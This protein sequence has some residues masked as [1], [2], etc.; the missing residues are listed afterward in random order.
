LRLAGTYH[1]IAYLIERLDQFIPGI[2]TVHAVWK[3]RNGELQTENGKIAQSDT[4]GK[5]NAQKWRSKNLKLEW[6]KSFNPLNT[7]NSSNQQLKLSDEDE[8][9]VLLIFF[10]STTDNYKDI[11]A[12]HFPQYLFLGNLNST[13]SAMSTK[14]KTVLSNI[15]SS[16]LY[17]EHERCLKEFELL[18]QIETHQTRQG[19]KITQL[20]SNLKQSEQLYTSALKI[21][22]HDIVKVFE[23]NLNKSIT[24][25]N[26]VILRLAKER[27]SK[28]QITEILENAIHVA[29]NLSISSNE[30]V[31][32]NDLVHIDEFKSSEKQKEVNSEY[33]KVKF[34]L[35]R[36]E[37]AAESARDNGHNVNGKNV[38]KH[39]DPPVTPP[40]ITDAIKK[41][42]KKI[43]YYLEKYPNHW[44]LV[45]SKLRPLQ[46]IDDELGRSYRGVG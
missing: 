22:V 46:I 32:H 26:D 23:E 14:E 39:L 27:I 7:V 38:A 18:K 41:N 8:L 36:Y 43:H 9:N 2:E 15:L 12:I 31:I 24:I 45:R 17:A 10:N 44:T 1:P 3:D 20:T 5:L 19:E 16:V 6:L 4:S 21:I 42:E 34:L 28:D 33:D 40:A 37:A 35:D 25:E 30:L 11:I 13:F 29:Y